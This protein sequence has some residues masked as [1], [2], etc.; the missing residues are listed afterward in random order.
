[1]GM[2]RLSVTVPGHVERSI[3]SAAERAGVP[4]SQWIARIAEQAAILE[5]GSRAIEEWEAEHGPMSAAAD[6]RARAVLVRAGLLGE[7]DLQRSG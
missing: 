4:V 1:M 2:S 3:R 5:D 6:E 7:G